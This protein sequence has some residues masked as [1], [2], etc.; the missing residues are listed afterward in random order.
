MMKTDLRTNEKVILTI[1]KH[2]F[3]LISPI[4]WTLLF[5]LISFIGYQ[6]EYVIVFL[7]ISGLALLWLI[8]K[9]IDRKSNIWVVTNFRVIDESGV[10]TINSKESP[11]DKINNVSYRKPFIGR[12]FNFGDVEIQTAAEMG[13]ST[14]QM[15]EK[16]QL[17]KDSITKSQENYRQLQL[18][19]QAKTYA[20][21][22]GGSQIDISEELTKLHDLMLK[23]IITEEE[24]NQRKTKILN[25]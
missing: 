15:V 6:S 23:G 18:K 11:L 20:S 12:I 25:S 9:I 14:H 3:T 1:R 13:S 24:F 19:E 7:M 8:Y 17:L 21:A 10:F 2:G 16:P 22:S 5:L 4:F